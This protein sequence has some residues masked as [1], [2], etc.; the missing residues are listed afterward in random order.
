MFLKGY[1]PAHYKPIESLENKTA[2]LDPN[3]THFILVDDGSECK[4]GG[5]IELRSKFEAHVSMLKTVGGN[6][7]PFY[8]MLLMLNFHS[9]LSYCKVSRFRHLVSIPRVIATTVDSKVLPVN[10]VDT[11]AVTKATA[12]LAYDGLHFLLRCL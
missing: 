9:P 10:C 8:S 7:R 6:S 4:F 1:A 11:A 3:H 2:A 12:V 5:E